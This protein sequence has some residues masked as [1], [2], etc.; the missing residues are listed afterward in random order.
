MAFS[1]LPRNGYTLRAPCLQSSLGGAPSV[2]KGCLNGVMTAAAEA[3]V[4]AGATSNSSAQ[5]MCVHPFVGMLECAYLG[6]RLV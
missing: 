2:G 3:T 6:C 5:G 4:A 1:S